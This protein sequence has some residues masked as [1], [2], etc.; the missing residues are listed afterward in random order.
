MAK[1]EKP[2][3]QSQ[4]EPVKTNNDELEFKKTIEESKKAILEA[5]EP[6]KRGPGRPAKQKSQEATMVAQSSTEAVIST[7]A[8]DI[9]IF[10][11]TP[12]IMVSKLPAIKYQIP[13]LALTD[14]EAQACAESLNNVMQ[15]FVP[16]IGKMDPKTGAIIGACAVF[17]SVGFQKWQILSARRAQMMAENKTKEQ[18]TEIQEVAAETQLKSG[19]PADNYFNRQSV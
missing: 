9:S 19:I 12:L 14:D 4:T 10:I 17:G 1:K 18:K 5:Q 8:P 13:E 15:A 11:K 6:P 2:Q 3:N 16:D 7:P